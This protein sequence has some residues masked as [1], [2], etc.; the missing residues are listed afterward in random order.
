[1]V[2][3]L[4]GA[5]KSNFVQYLLTLEQYRNHLVY[6]VC[7]EHAG[8]NRYLPRHRSGEE[9]RVEFGE[10]VQRFVTQND[11]GLRPDLLVAEEVSRL[12]PN[13]GGAPD[14]LYDLV[15]LNRHYATG[16]LGVA[17]RPA[18]V[19]TNLVEL[20]DNILV[21][22]VRGKNDVKRLNEE[23]PGSGDAAADLEP[24]HFLR[25]QGDRSYSVHSPVPE[26]DTTGKL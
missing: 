3:G 17:R 4:K 24:Y 14:E 11:R 10:V 8:F 20:A 21:F 6:D 26:Q 22:T 18:Q 23:A 13:R 12:A 5:G 25:I 15:D 19:D 7:K 2:F 16:F 9:A 1:M